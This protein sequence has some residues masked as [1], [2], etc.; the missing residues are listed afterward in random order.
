MH[1]VIRGMCLDRPAGSPRIA[2]ILK[3]VGHVG[4]RT[5]YFPVTGPVHRTDLWHFISAE[6]DCPFANISI[7][8]HVDPSLV[9]V[10]P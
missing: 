9:G 2:I 10:L 4:Y 1:Y 3:P 6:L 5:V 8:D 7:A